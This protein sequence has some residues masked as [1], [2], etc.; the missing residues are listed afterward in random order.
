MLK[1]TL[2]CQTSIFK[3]EP[4]GSSHAPGRNTLLSAWAAV[5]PRVLLHK[6]PKLKVARKSPASC[7]PTPA[8]QSHCQSVPKEA[9]E[10]SLPA[11]NTEPEPASA[12]PLWLSSCLPLCF[13]CLG[14]QLLGGQTCC[15][16]PPPKVRTELSCARLRRRVAMSPGPRRQASSSRAR[17]S[18]QFSHMSWRR[19]SRNFR[20]NTHDWVSRAFQSVA[21]EDVARCVPSCVCA[22]VPAIVCSCP[23]CVRVCFSVSVSA[24][25][26]ECSSVSRART[27]LALWLCGRSICFGR[28]FFFLSLSLSLSVS[29]SVSQS[30]CLSVCLFV[31]PSLRLS[32]SLSLFCSALSLSLSVCSLS[33]LSLSLAR[34]M[35]LISMMLSMSSTRLMM[36]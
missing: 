5:F 20:G 1:R 25:D 13:A 23:S 24:S 16:P 21:R 31:S 35:F 3:F 29:Q 15:L 12:R 33:L 32:V 4:H 10:A 28:C 36:R 34:M 11:P 6:K 18:A 17:S 27:S 2:G 26:T 9:H 30:V 7:Q 8:P 14:H 22:F 19:P